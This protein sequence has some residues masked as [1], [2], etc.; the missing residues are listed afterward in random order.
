MVL[1]YGVWML[2]LFTLGGRETDGPSQVL[3][4]LGWALAMAVP[5]FLGATAGTTPRALLAGRWTAVWMLPA[6]LWLSVSHLC[7]PL[8]QRA[9]DA[10][11]GASLRVVLLLP[12]AY[13]FGSATA[14]LVP[15]RAERA[16][17]LTGQG[18]ATVTLLVTLASVS[19]LRLP[20]LSAYLQGLQDAGTF[21]FAQGPVEVLPAQDDGRSPAIAARPGDNEHALG[22]LVVTL[23]G[24]AAWLRARSQAGSACRVGSGDHVNVALAEDRHLAVLQGSGQS[25]VC[26]DDHGAWRVARLGDFLGRV[27]L[28][29]TW[30]LA[31]LLALA[32][33]VLLSQR[34]RGLERELGDPA[35]WLQAELSEGWLRF[36][37][38]AGRRRASPA[39]EAFQGPV[40]VIPVGTQGPASYRDDGAPPDGYVVPG[41]VEA[42][43]EAHRA[44]A[45]AADVLLLAF[46]LLGAAPLL[47]AVA[48]GALWG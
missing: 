32:V 9:S 13:L 42:L 43:R 12:A 36:P 11:F 23:D 21:T 24:N 19:T 30:P 20:S 1:G 26:A 33:G 45:L 3:P 6:V 28:P 17:R 5:A 40:V 47:T 16:L 15:L 27:R 31:A 46:T 22:A 35:R 4:V 48:L 34:A 39:V 37:N 14:R 10:L 29:W 2:A 38:S 7:A 41:T 8:S 44:C 25:V 18:V